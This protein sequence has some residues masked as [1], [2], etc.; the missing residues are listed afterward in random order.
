MVSELPWQYGLRFDCPE[1][2]VEQKPDLNFSFPP[3][4]QGKSLEQAYQECG[5]PTTEVIA[6]LTEPFVCSNQ[7]RPV[8]PP[9]IGAVFLVVLVQ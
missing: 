1:C 2:G 8:R 4:F 3:N 9:E 7:Q 5:Q 6:L